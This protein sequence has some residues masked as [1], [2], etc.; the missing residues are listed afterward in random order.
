MILFR[1]QTVWK[2]FPASQTLPFLNSLC[3]SNASHAK[4]SAV[5][6]STTRLTNNLNVITNWLCLNQH[7][8]GDIFKWNVTR[9]Y[10][11]TSA[12][13]EDGKINCNVGTIGHVD[14]GKTTLTA[15][16]TKLQEKKGLSN[17][18]PYDEIDRAPEEKRRGSIQFGFPK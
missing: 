10:S 6:F 8:N 11:S 13:K 7:K 16:I 2:R 14:H 17:Y 18:V 3:Y 5:C 4:P 9:T 1:H 15:A 12:P